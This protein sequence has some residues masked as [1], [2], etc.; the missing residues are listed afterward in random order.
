M[1]DLSAIK[2]TLAA[3][4]QAVTGVP[5]RAYGWV[6]DKPEVPSGGVAFIV[7]GPAFGD[8]TYHDVM[9]RGTCNLKLTVMAIA[10]DTSDGRAE[11]LLDQVMSAGT[12][13]PLSLFDAFGSVEF[14]SSPP[15]DDCQI[16]QA[17]HQGQ[18]QQPDANTSYLRADFDILIHRSRS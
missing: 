16:V 11:R 4:I 13:A 2:D 1:I 12:G 15:W 8:F 3:R 6:T 7:S 5:C 14:T 9:A 18:I 10:A 17:G